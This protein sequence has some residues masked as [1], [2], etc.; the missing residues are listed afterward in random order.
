MKHI[1]KFTV[2]FQPRV[3]SCLLALKGPKPSRQQI[4]V[5]SVFLI[6][7]LALEYV[8]VS[9]S[10]EFGQNAGNMP[11]QS[12]TVTRDTWCWCENAIFASVPAA[13]LGHLLSSYAYKVS[14]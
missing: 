10:K 8:N 9:V 12:S 2:A 3:G 1:N 13:V 14:D 11:G 7:S 4:T 5:E 6:L